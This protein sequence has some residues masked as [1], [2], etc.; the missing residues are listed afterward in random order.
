MKARA[1]GGLAILLLARAAAAEEVEPVTARLEWEARAPGCMDAARLAAAVNERW[2]RPVFVDEGKADLVLSGRAE[3]AARGFVAIIELSR[4]GGESLGSRRLETRSSDCKTL[5]DS[6][7]LA[8][9]LM[10]DVSRA[11]V[12]EER[13]E[14][15]AAALAAASSAGKSEAPPPSPPPAE[16]LFDGP[17]IVVPP[18]K[19]P[20]RPFTFE[21][22]LGGELAFGLLP[23]LAF[24]AR[25]GVSIA[26]PGFARIEI[27]GSWFAPVDERESAERGVRLSALSVDLGLCVDEWKQGAV[28]L[29]GCIT[30]RVGRVRASGFGLT[31]PETAGD[32]LVGAGLREVGILSLT[33][34]LALRAGVALEVPLVRYRFVFEDIDRRRQVAYEMNRVSVALELGVALHLP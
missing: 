13:R 12:A 26:P 6:V 23:P 34:E 25:A 14:Q 16:R 7:A 15:R 28:R 17:P 11:R 4:E 33:P 32:L 10:L 22:W 30:E 5:D 8:V 2:D 27:A 21:P 9:G 3:R 1:A 24:G 29:H 18:P 31:Q 20:S 19:E